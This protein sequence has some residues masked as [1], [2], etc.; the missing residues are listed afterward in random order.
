VPDS[1]GRAAAASMIGCR[2]AGMDALPQKQRGKI[3]M[4]DYQNAVSYGY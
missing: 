2:T 3:R 4:S 1:A